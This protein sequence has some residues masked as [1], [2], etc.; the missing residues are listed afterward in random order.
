MIDALPPEQLCVGC[1]TPR[2]VIL[3]PN[4]DLTTRWAASAWGFTLQSDCFEPSAYAQFYDEHIGQGQEQECT[5]GTVIAPDT[6]P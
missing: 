1:P 6:C 2:R 5:A 4:P 3:T